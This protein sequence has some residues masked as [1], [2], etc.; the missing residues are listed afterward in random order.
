MIDLQKVNKLYHGK[1][2]VK[3]VQLT[4]PEKKLTAF[5]GPNGAG[6]STVLSMIS[7]LIPK[8]TGEIYLDHNEVKAWKS[9][10]LAKKLS[11]LRQSNEINV[12]ITVK[13]LVEFGRFPY[14]KGK[15]TT[16]DQKIVQ[17]SPEHLGLEE[18]ADQSIDTLSGGQLQRA[19]IAMVLAQD[20]DYILL[21]EPLNNLDM[22]FAV[23]IMQILKNL[24]QKIGKTIVIVLHDINFAASYADEIIAMKDGKLFTQGTTQEMIKKDVLDELYEMDIRIC[25]IEGRRF[26]LYF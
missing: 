15:L 8:D 19:Y 14:T 3:D 25:E 22:N 6:K 23:Q 7:R 2:V 1:S 13:E 9:N 4:I 26:C 21:D 12:Q 11:I 17:E 24:V 5:I 16:K 10:E 20:T 18:I